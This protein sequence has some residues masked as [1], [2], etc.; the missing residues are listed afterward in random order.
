MGVWRERVGSTVPLFR[1]YS[2]VA[3]D[4]FYTTDAQK[5]ENTIQ[6]LGYNDEGIAAHVNPKP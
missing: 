1:M 3:A 6:N 5:R 2:P 4:R